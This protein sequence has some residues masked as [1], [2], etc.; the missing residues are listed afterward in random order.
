MPSLTFTFNSEAGAAF[1]NEATVA[2]QNWKEVLGIDVK[3]DG[4]GRTT[5]LREINATANN[6]NGLQMWGADWFASY[7]DPQNWTT[8]QF[9]KGADNNAI[10]YEQK[11]RCE[12]AIA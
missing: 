2:Q 8:L 5:L 4:V 10:N 3:L 9:A 7:P 11:R 1:R 6:A 12:Q